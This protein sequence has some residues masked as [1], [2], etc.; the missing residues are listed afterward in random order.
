MKN[1]KLH[2][3]A[4]L[5]FGLLMGFPVAFP[6]VV[7]AQ[8]VGVVA[9]IRADSADGEGTTDIGQR[10]NFQA[11]VIGKFELSG[12]LQ[13]RSG[14]LYVQRGYELKGTNSTDQLTSTYFEVPVGLLYK[15]SDFG[16]VFI[17]PALG[18]GLSKNCPASCNGADV[19]SSLVSVQFGASFKIAPQFGFE[20][21]YE[22]LTGNIAKGI[23]NPRAIVANAMITFD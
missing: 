17:G 3:G 18:L 20:V 11:G 23:K 9:G 5:A 10:V 1:Q 2:L 22:A 19:A 6:T 4:M 14:M 12:P 13:I 7:K 21:Y 16:G 15:F 8:D